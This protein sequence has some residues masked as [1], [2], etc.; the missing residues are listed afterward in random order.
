MAFL[1]CFRKLKKLK[2]DL[3]AIQYCIIVLSGKLL[4]E[5]SPIVRNDFYLK[6]EERILIISGPNQG[7]KTTFARTFGQLYCLAQSADHID[8]FIKL[9]RI[10]L[11]FYIGCLNLHDQLDQIGE[12]TAF[13][14]PAA[15]FG[16]NLCNS[17]LKHYRREEDAGMESGKLDEELG[18]MSD[19]VDHVKPDVLILF[20]ES[21]A[22]TNEW[23]GSEIAGQITRALVEQRV[24]TS[25]V[26]HLHEFPRWFYDRHKDNA[27]FLRAQ[28]QAG[29]RRTFKMI[30]GEPRQASYGGDLYSSIFE[31]IN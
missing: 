25:C 4:A 13:P 1:H 6:G 7:G 21:F 30:G 28:R 9:L 15:S 26:T 31:P 20:N 8:K 23:E 19:I 5:R 16:A 11:A 27:L 24:K 10:E 3:T 18:R 2:I 14:E 22:V 29:G 17:P 12:P